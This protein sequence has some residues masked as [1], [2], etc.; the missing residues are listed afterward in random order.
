[1]CPV[2][3]RLLCNRDMDAH[4]LEAAL[5]SSLEEVER[6]Q[7]IIE[8]LKAD[9][10]AR[11]E[12]LRWVSDRALFYGL[13][14][15]SNA[16]R[17]T[18]HDYTALL[19]TRPGDRQSWESLCAAADADPKQGLTVGQFSAHRADPHADLEALADLPVL[20]GAV[21]T[22][23]EATPVARMPGL[24][25]EKRAALQRTVQGV[26]QEIIKTEEL[27]VEALRGL[28]EDFY[29]PLLDSSFGVEG[30]VLD[31]EHVHKIFGNVEDIL[32]ISEELLGMLRARITSK[33]STA[34][35]SDGLKRQGVSDISDIFLNMGFAFKLYSR[36]ISRFE[37]AAVCLREVTQ[38]TGHEKF[39][40]WLID[41]VSLVEA[42]KF[43]PD[44]ANRV[45]TFTGPAG[46]S[47]MNMLQMTGST[48]YVLHV[49]HHDAMLRT[50]DRD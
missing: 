25:D 48:R 36:Y 43:N 17:V 28:V 49:P 6:H 8:S 14:S 50:S 22:A 26:L 13:A 9:R 37:K 21:R 12:R 47:S 41:T 29:R 2:A 39:I 35:E 10:A 33:M 40:E 16:V 31:S 11:G 30:A 18:E 38:G 44:L 27:Y 7:A 32:L 3:D 46:G 4:A 24:T 1:M 15:S 34:V 45:G 20:R 23:S 19:V 42:V 5:R